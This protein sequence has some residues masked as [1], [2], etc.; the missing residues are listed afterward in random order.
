M[1][2]LITLEGEPEIEILELSGFFEQENIY[3]DGYV[4]GT[5]YPDNVKVNLN[6]HEEWIDV[7]SAELGFFK[8]FKFPSI[9][10]PKIKIPKIKAPKLP[11]IK[12]KAPKLPKIKIPKVKLPKLPKIK[13]PKIKLPNLDPSILENLLPSSNPLDENMPDEQINEIEESESMESEE[14][15]QDESEV[16]ENEYSESEEIMPDYES[17]EV[18]FAPMAMMAG[19]SLLPMIQQGIQQKQQANKIKQQ[20][21]NQLQQALIQRLNPIKP[22]PKPVQ[23]V[24][25]KPVQKPIL[26]TTN[27]GKMQLAVKKAQEDVDFPKSKDN[28]LLMIGGAVAL[29]A[30]L[31]LKKGK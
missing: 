10:I 18:G 5:L 31:F 17:T 6:G 14:F 7:R 15:T 30:I 26:R 19:Q 24:I 13:L 16:L 8:G 20:N 11:K 23:R 27:T 9:K 12:I 29:A 4:S 1:T 2:D 22:S 3:P 21:K 25:K 28:N